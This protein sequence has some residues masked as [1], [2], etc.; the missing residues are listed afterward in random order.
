MKHHLTELL[1]T[2][3]IIPMVNQMEF[4]PYLVQQELIDFCSQKGIQYEAWSPLMRGKI[5]DID[6]LKGLAKKYEKNIV[7]IVLRWNLQKGVVTIPKSSNPERIKS[8]ADIFDFELSP[9]DMNLIDA[10]NRNLRIGPDPDN[11]TF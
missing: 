11:F 5:L 10:L 4:H 2:C 6:F 9:E 8:N 1:P 7:Q 3:S